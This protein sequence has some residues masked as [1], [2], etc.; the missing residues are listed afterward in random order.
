MCKINCSSYVLLV[1]TC[2]YEKQRFHEIL[3]LDIPTARVSVN[4]NHAGD[5]TLAG[6]HSGSTHLP[7]GRRFA[8]PDASAV[9][10]NFLWHWVFY[11]RHN[12][13]GAHRDCKVGNLF[14][15]PRRYIPYVKPK[16]CELGYDQRYDDDGLVF[17]LQFT[18]TTRIN[19]MFYRLLGMKV[20]RDVIIDTVHVYDV[21]LIEMGDRA[22]I[23][24]DA[25]IM[26][27]VLEGDSVYYKR[28]RIGRGAIIGY[29][30]IVLAGA[31]IGDGAIVGAGSL[32]LKDT[33]LPPRTVWGGIPVRKIKDLDSENR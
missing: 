33:V 24:G 10:G 9:C 15:L 7:L 16:T 3:V 5:C 2:V 13:A 25:V 23:G 6:I 20:G 26:A 27:H 11:F 31:E 30:T 29:G 22:V 21:D 8:E 1:T 18:R 17:F 12:L 14:P 19:T 32:V 28:T 4:G